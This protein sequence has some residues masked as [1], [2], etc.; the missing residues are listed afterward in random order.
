MLIRE[1]FLEAYFLS[2]ESVRIAFRVAGREIAIGSQ[3]SVCTLTVIMA[4]LPC[5]SD[6]LKLSLLSLQY[7]K[8]KRSIS[9]CVS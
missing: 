1:T 7:K 6:W 2:L 8:C 5:Q 9:S 3:C 4:T